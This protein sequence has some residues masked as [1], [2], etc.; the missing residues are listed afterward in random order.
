MSSIQKPRVMIVEDQPENISILVELLKEDYQLMPLTSG[1]AALKRLDQKPFPDLV[2]LDIVMPGMDG[3]DVCTRIKNNPATAHIP[4]IFITAVSEA[5]DDA[6]AFKIG[7]VDYITKPFNPLT[8]KA[9]VNTHVKLSRT[10]NDLK[11]ALDEIKTLNGL[12]P[13]CAA[14]KKIRDDQGYWEEVET[15]ISE[16]SGATF[17]HG[18]CPDCRDE[19]YPKYKKSTKDQS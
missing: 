5:M 2:L 3:Y 14:C 17:S 1:E 19:L 8:V 12:I 18:I 13:I 6:N 10:M 9:R 4:V 7:A 16:R 15:Y 11:H